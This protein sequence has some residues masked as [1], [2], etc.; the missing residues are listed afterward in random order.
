M[1]NNEPFTV[2]GIMPEGSQFPWDNIEV[3]IPFQHWPSFNLN[4]N[5]GHGADVGRI[6]PGLSIEAAQ[7]ELKVIAAR[8]IQIYPESNADRSV[9]LVPMK[10]LWSPLFAVRSL[11]FVGAVA[12]F[13][14]S[15]V[16]MQ[17]TCC[18]YIRTG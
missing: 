8:Q 14:S 13:C 11:V 12:L 5:N 10:K 17:P 7:T 9:D 6:N 1:L 18:L 15:R 4:R 2:I 16:P 3:W